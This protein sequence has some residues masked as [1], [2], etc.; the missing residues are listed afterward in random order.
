MSLT[1]IVGC[2]FSGKSTE[3][4]RRVRRHMAI[5]NT[6]AIINSA[7]DTRCDDEVLCTHDKNAIPCTKTNDI[8]TIADMNTDVIAIDEGQFFTGLRDTVENLLAKNKHVIVGGLDG[9]FRQM[10]FGE[11]PL[12]IPL[13]DEIVKLHAMCMICKDGTPAPFTKRTVEET[14]QELVGAADKYMAVC[15]AHLS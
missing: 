13:A 7:K 15:R 1:L 9:D 5:G 14:G 8:S 6:V 11:I 2:M 4:L 12:L 3:I 10:P